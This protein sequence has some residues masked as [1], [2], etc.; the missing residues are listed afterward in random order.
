MY[1]NSISHDILLFLVHVFGQPG[2]PPGRSSFL[3]MF[4][5][6]YKHVPRAFIRCIILYSYIMEE[7]KQSSVPLPPLQ[8]CNDLRKGVM[9]KIVCLYHSKK[10]MMSFLQKS[11]KGVNS[12]RPCPGFHYLTGPENHRRAQRIPAL[13]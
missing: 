8:C 1:R 3:S 5:L 10:C 12:S 4:Y 9:W 6:T 2:M 11:V 7:S 13:L